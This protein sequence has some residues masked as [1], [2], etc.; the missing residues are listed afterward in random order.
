MTEF[1]EEYCILLVKSMY[2]NMY[3]DLLWLIL[4]TKCLIQECDMK[5]IQADFCIFYNNDDGGK[6]DLVMYVHVENVF[7][8]ARSETLEKNKY[9]IK[10][11]FNI[12]YSG[13]VKRFL[14]LYY[15]WG[16]DAKGMYAKIT[17]EKYIKILVDG[18]KKLTGGDVKDQKTL[19]APGTTMYL[20]FWPPDS[21]PCPNY[22]VMG[23]QP[24]AVDITDL[25]S[26]NPPIFILIPTKQK[27]VCHGRDESSKGHIIEHLLVTSVSSLI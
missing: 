23:F 20:C 1:L 24:Q 16:H 4:L 12:Q 2:G 15:E 3:N 26:V 17:V 18:Y 9:M 7:M 11:K 27:D 13:I 10:L 22:E 8:A 19:G 6:L 5:R 25:G 14:G 21:I